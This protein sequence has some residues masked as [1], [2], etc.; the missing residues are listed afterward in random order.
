MEV[1][2]RHAADGPDVLAVLVAADEKGEADLGEED[3]F[4]D[5]VQS[6]LV[7]GEREGEGEG[8]EEGK[9][10]G[11][12]KAERG[13]ERGREHTWSAVSKGVP[14]QSSANQ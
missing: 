5:L 14:S 2:G 10:E 6:V 4:D 11:E 9:R 8:E 3:D 1:V 13:I 7:R 12:A